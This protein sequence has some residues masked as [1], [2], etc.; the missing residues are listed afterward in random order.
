MRSE[1]L[2]QTKNDYETYPEKGKWNST[3]EERS[4]DR[5]TKVLG[6]HVPWSPESMYD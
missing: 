3:S 4:C 5:L 1:S 2:T 6:V